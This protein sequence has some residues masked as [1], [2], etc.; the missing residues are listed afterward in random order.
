MK[1]SNEAW[2]LGLVAIG[3]LLA[4]ALGPVACKADLAKPTAQRIAE[5]VVDFVSGAVTSPHDSVSVE[6]D[7]VRVYVP[8]ADV[9]DLRCDLYSQRPVVGSVPVRV[10]LT[11]RD[12]TVHVMSVSAK[13]RL[14]DT[15]AV[16]ARKLGRLQSV[17]DSDLRLERREVTGFTDGY[18]TALGDFGNMRT[19]RLVIAGTVLQ[20]M[21]VEA[22]P[23]VKRG[24]G[25]VVAVVVGGVTV[26][27]KA[28]A[29]EDGELGDTI[30]VQ[31]VVT[32]KRLAATVM[33]GT[34]VV[35][36]GSSL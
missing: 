1:P 27:S 33:G 32:G 21:D 9:V 18:F 14:F 3:F 36:D 35:H 5:A 24:T 2:I 22:I 23:V 17:A 7:P 10:T 26:I 19:T 30:K 16:A 15:V 6:V 8:A 12:G 28:R 25:V 29:L 34:L 31:D 11:L 13:V 20:N 4:L